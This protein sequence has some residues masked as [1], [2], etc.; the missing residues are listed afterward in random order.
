VG[1]KTFREV[2]PGF[3]PPREFIL[4]YG[5]LLPGRPA[6]AR[7]M[8]ARVKRKFGIE[9]EEEVIYLPAGFSMP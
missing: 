5:G 8:K 6:L 3:M 7:M 4:N 2:E 1:A 9:L